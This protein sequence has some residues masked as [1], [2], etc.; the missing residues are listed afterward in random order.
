MKI[1][2]LNGNPA[3]SPFDTYL[4]QLRLKL[5]ESNHAV[6]QLN[7][8]ELTLHYCIGCWGCWVKTPGICAHNDQSPELDQTI[9]NADFVLWASPLIMG[10]PSEVLKR[11]LDKHVPLI[12]PYIVEDQG[13][14]HHLGRYE[15]YPRL[16]LL[17]E[18]EA[19]TNQNQLEIVSTIF[20]RTA[21]NFKSKLEFVM[22][23]D[24]NII[25]LVGHILSST[26]QHPLLPEPLS[27]I[28]GERITTPTKLTL[29]N[30][31]P[32]GKRASTPLMLEQFAKGFGKGY[33]MHHLVYLKNT[34]DFIQAFE[35]AE[36]VWLGFPLYTDA[37]PAITKHFIEALEPLTNRQNNPPIG[38]LVQSGFI[39][40]LHSRY[41]E[42]YLESLA[43]RLGSP[44]LGTIVKGGGEATYLMPP[45]ATKPL[46]SK[47]QAL[48]AG[49]ALEGQLDPRIMK[50]I[51][52]PE[53]F[54]KIL[55]PL[56]RYFMTKPASHSYFD[57][58]LKKNGVFEN[59]YARPFVSE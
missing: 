1:T 58:M 57:N 53:R 59:R 24:C 29:F 41:V 26:P 46:F 14:M 43:N 18:P 52:S 27:P 22:T 45:Q 42:R 56:L 51:A 39:E 12:H 47:L 48:G 2:I 54:P 17:L 9:I 38:F 4:E 7:L 37:M 28:R 5:E 35:Q 11:A 36:C 10:Y 40:G 20:Q 32:R 23:T 50:K 44:Y 6:T 25:E 19:E 15:H 30:G 3:P 34:P 49:F 16:G 8:R 33:E 13:E 55:L 31:S 21:L